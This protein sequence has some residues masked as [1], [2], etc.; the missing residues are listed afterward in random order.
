MAY[1]VT[2]IVDHCFR[3]TGLK[4]CDFRVHALK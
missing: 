2:V 4:F 1:P 3:R